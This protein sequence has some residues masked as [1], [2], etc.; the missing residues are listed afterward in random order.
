VVIRDISAIP[1]LFADFCAQGESE[2]W[3]IPISDKV[4]APAIRQAIKR[5]HGKM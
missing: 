3:N 2:I 4:T 5:G 1:K